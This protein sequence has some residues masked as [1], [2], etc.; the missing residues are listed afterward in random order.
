VKPT[1]HRHVVPRLGMPGA[2]PLLLHLNMCVGICMRR[3][4]FTKLSIL[5]RV[6]VTIEGVRIGDLIY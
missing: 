2:I 6:C 4:C 3:D 1:T 5:S